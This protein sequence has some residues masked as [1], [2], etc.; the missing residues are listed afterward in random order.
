V[1]LCFTRLTAQQPSDRRGKGADVNL[2]VDLAAAA[3]DLV[4]RIVFDLA[5][6]LRAALRARRRRRLSAR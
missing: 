3:A 4:A 1:W 2:L 6:D 5:S